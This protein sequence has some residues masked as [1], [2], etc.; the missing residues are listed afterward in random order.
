[1]SRIGNKVIEV[2][3]GVTVSLDG[4]QVEVKGPK[5]TLSGTVPSPITAELSDN[6]LKLVRPD[7]KKE[8]RALHGLARALVANMVG[9][10]TDGFSR[11]LEIVGVGYRADVKGKT[12][13]LTLGF[14]HP[15][16]MPI[17]DGLSVSVEEN[18]KLKVEGADKG[19]VG[20]FSAE[21]RKLRP[22][23]PYT[24]KGV[25]Y[26]DERVRRKVGKAGV[27]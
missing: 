14:S 7:E 9:G 20:Q 18:T 15:V 21:I 23:E 25:R 24:G 26:S 11:E 5:G 10:V 1:M 22:P 16:E 13:N 3:S 4:A 17:P 8:T 27:G 2:P 12:L 19:M 6:E